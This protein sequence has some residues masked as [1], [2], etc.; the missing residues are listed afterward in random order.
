MQQPTRLYQYLTKL[1]HGGLC[2]AFSGGVDSTLLLAAAKQVTNRVL[3]VTVYTPFHSPAEPTEAAALAESI[4]VEHQILR[5]QLPD[6]LW[7]NPTNRC[8]ICKQ[9]LFSEIQAVA[10]SHG[11]AFVL[12]GTNADDHNQ[13]RPGL[14]ALKDLGIHSP[15]AQLGFSKAEVREMA[16]QLNL[17]VA[18]KPSTPCLATRFPYNHTLTPE[19]LKTADSL[20]QF[21][22]SLGF[23]VVRA[24]IHSDSLRL[25][26][27]TSHLVQLLEHREAIIAKAKAHGLF[28]VT[29]DL[30]GFRSGSMDIG[31]TQS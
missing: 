18:E 6:A 13:Y 9:A 4:G 5:P 3:A 31:L 30:E 22:R 27:P 26:V 8:Y 24:R 19:K 23:G 2:V 14:A 25:E 1:A 15:L 28:Y 21:V 12:D 16:R 10:K 29:L 17:A 11:L 7:A 20:E